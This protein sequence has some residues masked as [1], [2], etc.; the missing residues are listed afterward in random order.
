[1]GPSLAEV[2][3][4][5]WNFNVVIA[6]KIKNVIIETDAK[7]V[8]DSI[9]GKSGITSIDPIIRDCKCLMQKRQVII[10]FAVSRTK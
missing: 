7:A 8:V 6:L 4:I 5:S 3:D 1:M 2:M 10:I 9:N